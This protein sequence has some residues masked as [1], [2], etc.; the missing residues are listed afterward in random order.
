M[1]SRTFFSITFALLFAWLGTGCDSGQP[2]SSSADDATASETAP[3]REPAPVPESGS[4]PAAKPARTGDANTREPVHTEPPSG[5]LIVDITDTGVV[6][7]ASNV[8]QQAILSEL[9]RRAGF[10]LVTAGVAWEDVSMTIQAIDL[11]NALVEVLKPHPYQIIYEYDHDFRADALTRV[12]VGA[13]VSTQQGIAM[14]PGT[15]ATVPPGSYQTVTGTE[16]P[17]SQENQIHL[18]LLLDPSPEVRQEAAEDIEPVGMALDYLAEVVTSDPSPEVRIA[19]VYTLQD[20]KDPRAFDALI[21]GLQ[22]SDPE[23]LEE[24]IDAL[25]KTGNSNAIPY[26]QPFLDHSDSDVRRATEDAINDLQ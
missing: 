15:L 2:P 23:V 3:A 18:N 4:E 22:N 7:M 24:V 5:D 13:H 20:S 25:W 16:V 1:L 6:I 26:L 8:S 19:A 12:V 17:L 14:A 11:H 10:E 9:A 21:S